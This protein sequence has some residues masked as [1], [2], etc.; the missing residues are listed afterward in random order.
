M[1]INTYNIGKKFDIDI[2]CYFYDAHNCFPSLTRVHIKSYEKLWMSVD[3][4][5]YR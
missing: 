2:S 3:M 1:S 4:D 5:D